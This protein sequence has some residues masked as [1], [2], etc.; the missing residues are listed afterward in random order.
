[1]LHQY[2]SPQHAQR[3]L[4]TANKKNRLRLEKQSLMVKEIGIDGGIGIG[5]GIG[6]TAEE[7]KRIDSEHDYVFETS[8]C[9]GRIQWILSAPT[10]YERM[11][12]I[13]QIKQAV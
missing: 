4:R 5:I 12:W 10:E 11:M 2:E 8:T 9:D 1:M 7:E 13:Q 3:K 6:G